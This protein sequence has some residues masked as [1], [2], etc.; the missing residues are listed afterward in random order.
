MNVSE[1]CSGVLTT[2]MQAN[3]G[4][5][6]FIHYVRTYVRMYEG[7][8][9]DGWSTDKA[10]MDSA[11]LMTHPLCL[12]LTLVS[13]ITYHVLCMCTASMIFSLSSPFNG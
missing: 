4:L 12:I 10:I 8:C 13:P 6:N 2:A 11:T 9:S 5:C 7:L 3:C 1:G